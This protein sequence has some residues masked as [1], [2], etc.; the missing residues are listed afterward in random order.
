[1][2]I[3]SLCDGKL[4]VI[5]PEEYKLLIVPLFC[6]LCKF[7]MKTKEDS[8]EFR[9]RKL[10][11]Q[12]SYEFGSK[13]PNKKSFIWTNYIERRRIQSRIILKLK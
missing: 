4:M 7:P 9:K 3:K 13:K 5:Y 6:P 1:M 8:Q 2:K 10:C 11:E 12:C